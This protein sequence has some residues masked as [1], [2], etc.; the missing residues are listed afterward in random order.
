MK[1]FIKD[2][3]IQTEY[4]R[5]VKNFNLIDALHRNN[6]ISTPLMI[7]A[8]QEL[9]DELYKF[10]ISIDDKNKYSIKA[11][12]LYCKMT[13]YTKDLKQDLNY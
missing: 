13:A 11:K 8:L 2:D 10:I 1:K 7:V 9:L 5:F 6:G 3:Y 4:E 12:A